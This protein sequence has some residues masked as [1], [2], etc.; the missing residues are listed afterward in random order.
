MPRPLPRKFYDRDPAVV[1]RELLGALLIREADDG[2]TTGIIV[3]TEAYLA[4]RDSASHS[5]RGPT[6]R[7]A[8]MFGPPGYAYVYTIH[9]KFCLNTV[10]EPRGRGSAILI[11]AIDPVVGLD[12]M[13]TRRGSP[14]RRN[15]TR[16]PARLCQ[17]MA[18]DGG[19]D[20][21]NLTKVGMLWIA[22]ST[23]LPTSSIGTSPRIGISTARK[24]KLRFFVRGNTSVSGAARLNAS[25]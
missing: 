1:A 14:P 25:V 22:Q 18:V 23:I 13:N 15:L 2:R 3:E 5:S 10:T 7:N 12:L 20:G 19:Q 16:G 9:A 17:A 21:C 24:R 6:R 11:R 4:E 8:S